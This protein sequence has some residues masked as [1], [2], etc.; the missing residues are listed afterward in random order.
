VLKPGRPTLTLVTIKTVT[1]IS[2]TS[3]QLIAS[4]RIDPA[5]NYWRDQQKNPADGR[6]NL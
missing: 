6:G 3:Y 1:V 5:R 2:K 4:H